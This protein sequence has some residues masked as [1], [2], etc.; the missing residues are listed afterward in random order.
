MFW[1]LPFVYR[2]TVG[3]QC[4]SVAFPDRHTKKST[5]TDSLNFSLIKLWNIWT[6]FPKQENWKIL[7]YNIQILTLSKIAP[8]PP[9]KNLPP[10]PPLTCKIF[11]HLP[12]TCT[13]RNH[14]E[15]RKKNALIW[16]SCWKFYEK[17][18]VWPE[19]TSF[20]HNSSSSQ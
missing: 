12:N 1:H 13:C 11:L 19:I 4:Q 17:M 18:S 5:V 3:L 16:Q 14:A 9:R 10:P 8:P 15:N 20:V 6:Q 2:L 7:N